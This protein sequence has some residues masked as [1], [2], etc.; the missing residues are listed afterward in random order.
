MDSVSAKAVANQKVFVP[1]SAVMEVAA[2][3][4]RA[5][6]MADEQIN[7][8]V[9]PGAAKAMARGMAAVIK[10]LGLPIDIPNGY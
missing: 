1:L 10:A 8:G 5:V 4:S 2:T 3:L 7:K 6:G 9:S